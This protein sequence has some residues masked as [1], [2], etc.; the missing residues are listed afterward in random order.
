MSAD[1]PSISISLAG[2]VVAVT[3]GTK[4]IGR[5][6]AE[7]FLEAGATVA[8]CARSVPESLPARAGRVASFYQCDVRTAAACKDFVDAVAKDNGRLDVLINNAGGSPNV[9]AATVSPRFSESVINLNLMAPIHM[10]QAAHHWMD[11]QPEGGVIINIASISGR[12]PSPGTAAYGAAKA[13]LLSLTTS[14][15]QEWGPKVRVNAI[16]VGLIETEQSDV[17]YGSREAQLAIADSLPLKRMG[18]GEDIAG[19]ALF[20]ASP[21]A[22]FVSGTALEVHGGGEQ[23]PFLELIRRF[24]KLEAAPST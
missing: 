12:R 15:A 11:Q 7:A 23:P 16:I 19:A 21:L 18:R 14:L 6:I 10:S 9:A 22:A 20:L 8:V 2:Q 24:S 13:G 4:G 3:G 1:T 17:T 5:A